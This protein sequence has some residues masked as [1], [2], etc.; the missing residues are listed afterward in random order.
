MIHGLGAMGV[1]GML[2]PLQVRH[3]ERSATMALC[4][5][6]RRG[7]LGRPMPRPRTHPA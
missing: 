5:R 1:A 2:D 6:T 7:G 3:E 4:G